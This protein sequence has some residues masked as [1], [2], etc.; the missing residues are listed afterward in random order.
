M[1]ERGGETGE[2]EAFLF[3]SAGSSVKGR[4]VVGDWAEDD[5]DFENIHATAEA[6]ERAKSGAQCSNVS[7]NIDLIHPP[8]RYVGYV[9]D[10]ET[11]EMIMEKFQALEEL[12]KKKQVKGELTQTELEEIFRK[13]SKFSATSLKNESEGKKGGIS[14]YLQVYFLILI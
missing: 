14:S 7:C 2:D 9:D 3:S 4:F 10:Y 5:S 8:Q 11:P 13:T 12:E 1:R 6:R